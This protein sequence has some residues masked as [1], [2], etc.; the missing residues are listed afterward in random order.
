MNKL[1]LRFNGKHLGDYNMD[2]GDLHLDEETDNA[3]HVKKMI[4]DIERETH[5]EN[6]H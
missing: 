6:S 1:D 4:E 5:T 2:T 3:D